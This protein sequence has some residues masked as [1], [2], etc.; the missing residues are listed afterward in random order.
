[1]LPCARNKQGFTLVEILVVILMFSVFGIAIYSLY[2]THLKVSIRQEDVVDVQQNIRISMDRI[3][4]D[5][6]MA[7]FLVPPEPTGQTLPLVRTLANY[8]TTISIRTASADS[9]Y[10]RL[11]STATTAAA[12]NLGPL[13]VAPASVLD[14]FNVGDKVRIIRALNTT[15]PSNTIFSVF[16]TGST[17]TL[18]N[19]TS[20]VEYLPGD[21][22]CKVDS[23]AVSYKPDEVVYKII[24]CSGNGVNTTC[25]SRV[26]NGGA[27]DLIAQGISSLKFNYLL[28]DG[29]ETYAT[30][31]MTD[32]DKLSSLRAVRVTITGQTTK[33]G[34]PG[35][36]PKTRVLTSIVKLRNRR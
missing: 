9:T 31:N 25:L 18:V 5:I 19:S 12:A 7:G 6:M 3:T 20:D 26:V 24:A 13:S 29:T 16:E 34:S 8:S 21:V 27:D 22:I 1:M 33:K 28:D 11:N 36:L 32:L 2:L 15:Q 30:A 17:M 23:T 4:R 10:V 35:D 14:R